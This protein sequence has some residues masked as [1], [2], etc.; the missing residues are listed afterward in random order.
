MGDS[1]CLLNDSL[2]DW[3]RNQSLD[4]YVHIFPSKKGEIIEKINNQACIYNA[5]SVILANA[6]GGFFGKINQLKKL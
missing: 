5:Y 3:D 6:I 2:E 4:R 1:I